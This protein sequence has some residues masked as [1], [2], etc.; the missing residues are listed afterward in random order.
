[1]IEQQNLIKSICEASYK[2]LQEASLKGSEQYRCYP[3]DC[4]TLEDFREISIYED[5]KHKAMFDE[6]NSFKCPVLYWFEIIEPSSTEIILKAINRCKHT[7]GRKAIPAILK[8][9]YHGT[10]VLYVGKVIRGF[11]GRVVTHLGFYKVPRTQGLQ[12]FYWSIPIKLKLQL[13][14]YT[15]KPELGPIMGVLETGMAR[16]L[17]PLLG[18]HK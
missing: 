6:L 3:I 17:K 11:S 18:K 9:P 16:K 1:M 2:P 4:A 10:N 7:A 14:L 13:H 5:A 15:F 12:L 8:S